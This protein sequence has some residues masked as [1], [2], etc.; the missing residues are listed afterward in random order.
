MS[1]GS[2]FVNFK[3]CDPRP[4]R[5]CTLQFNLGRDGKSQVETKMD[6]ET[7]DL[8]QRS[9][10]F[11]ASIIQKEEIAKHVIFKHDLL[12]VDYWKYSKQA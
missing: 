4:R 1:L 12:C 6:W 8:Q 11:G 9:T 5:L 10:L 2:K 7:W 3:K